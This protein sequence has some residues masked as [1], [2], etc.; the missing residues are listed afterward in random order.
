M[1]RLV[2]TIAMLAVL[3]AFNLRAA[4]SPS[5]NA[6]KAPTA[7]AALTDSSPECMAVIVNKSN[8]TDT[9]SILDLRKI[10]L[11]ERRTWPN[12][13][14]I[15]VVMREPGHP[16][17][18][19]VLRRICRMTDSDFNRYLLHASFVGEVQSG[20]KVLASGIGI[21][22]FVVNVPGAIGYVNVKDV[23]DSVKPIRID[24]HSINQ[25]G[26]SMPA[27]Q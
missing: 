22:R 23:D 13:R 19:A 2:I 11:A 17:R 15:T 26:C 16:E 6:G 4:G 12:G 3:I 21:R 20:P 5:S 10:T 25:A 14:K 1:F 9:L 27:Q 7:F 24:G 18:E 8:P